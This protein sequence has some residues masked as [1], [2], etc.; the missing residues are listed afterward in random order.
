MTRT[1]QDFRA[2]SVRRAQKPDPDWIET[3]NRMTDLFDQGEEIQRPS[4]S[5]VDYFFPEEDGFSLDT[6]N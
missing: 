4:A 1:Q 2:R 5:F 3:M 6:Y